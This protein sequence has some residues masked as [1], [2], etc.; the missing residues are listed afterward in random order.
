MDKSNE[1]IKFGFSEGMAI[2]IEEAYGYNYFPNPS[3]GASLITKDYSAQISTSHKGVGTDHA[4]IEMVK[5][6]KSHLM[7][8]TMS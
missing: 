4:E 7:C 3:V 1:F 2:A 8:R 6:I 5:T